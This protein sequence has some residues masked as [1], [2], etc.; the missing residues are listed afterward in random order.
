[1][2]KEQL[3]KRRTE[4]L[5]QILILSIEYHELKL[6]TLSVRSHPHDFTAEMRSCGEAEL[7]ERICQLLGLQR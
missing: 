4:L 5:E 6:H 2:L 3:E 1:M 7:I